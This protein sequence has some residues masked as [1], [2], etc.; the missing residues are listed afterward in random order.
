VTTAG[1]SITSLS[2]VS[3]VVGTSVTIARA[4]FGSTKGTSTGHVQWH[5]GDADELVGDEHRGPGAGRRD[6]RER[7]RDGR[8]RGEQRRGVYGDQHGPSITN[9]APVSGAV[10]TS[11]TITGANFGSTKG[12]S[13]VTFNGTTATPTSWS[14]TSIVVPVP[15]GAT[16]GNVVATVGGVASNGVMFTVTTAAQISFVQVAYA[17][18]P[19][20]TTVP[21]TVTGAQAAGNLNVVV[22]G[23]NDAV[24]TVQSVTDSKGN[25][26][27]R[28]VGPTVLAGA[29]TQSI[30]YAKNIAAAA[31]GLEHRDG[32]VQRRGELLG[33]PRRGIQ[34]SRY[35]EPA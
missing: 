32:D 31:A 27:T 5:D 4:N 26:Y 20:A 16:T 24:R 2:P 12:T 25:V 15:T 35:G 30:Y 6:D 7:G 21:V 17:V 1:P 10:G 14:A 34:R 11:V 9:L 3:G 23:W 33:H 19:S 13:T 29:A 28:A 18:T 22:V 8:R